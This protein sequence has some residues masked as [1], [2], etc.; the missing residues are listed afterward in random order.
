[1]NKGV[2][3][4][5]VIY[6]AMVDPTYALNVFSKIPLTEDNLADYVLIAKEIRTHYRK[7]DTPISLDALHT[8]ITKAVQRLHMGDDKLEEQLELATSV[9]RLREGSN[10]S[11]DKELKD[12]IDY[13]SRNML[14]TNVLVR[15]LS[16]SK[17]VGSPDVVQKLLDG[18]SDAMASSDMSEIVDDVSLFDDEDNQKVVN[19]MTEND[20]EN[21]P[22]GWS[23]VDNAMGGGLSRGEMGLIIAPTGKGKT[24]FMINAAKQYAVNEGKN[25]LYIALE[26]KIKRLVMRIMR[27]V[28]GKSTSDFKDKYGQFDT[29]F[30]SDVLHALAKAQSDGQIGNL[31]IVTSR[32]QVVTPA[33]L[34]KI[35]QKYAAKNG[36]YPDVVMLDYPDLMENPYLLH[37]KVNEYRAAGMLYETL[38]RIASQYNFVL[39]VAS[40][41]NRTSA[42]QE[43]VNQY[44]I[45]GSKQKTNTV[46]LCL[47]VNQTDEEFKAGFIRFYI[48]KIRNPDNESIPSDKML[49]FKVNVHSV[50]FLEETEADHEAHMQVI[51]KGS[52]DKFGEYKKDPEKQ[53]KLADK[54]IAQSNKIIQQMFSK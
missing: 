54:K 39:W 12:Q 13:W 45:E 48:D 44:S 34:E 51:Q 46:E 26:E 37:S 52:S 17:D 11:N 16:G 15:E 10:Y 4:N 20:K 21:I 24:T 5:Q 6:R 38:R 3:L 22:I 27:T 40:Q 30:I 8:S 33:V 36:Y 29:K 23:N 18:I 43:I 42:S 2:L 14:I 31:S 53:K 49:Y 28:L 32:P 50:S 35:L 7:Y 1:M 9:N 47:S 25:V 41:T 19:L